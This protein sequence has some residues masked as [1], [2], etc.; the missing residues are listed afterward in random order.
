C[1]CDPHTSLDVS[2]T[3][4]G[5][6]RCQPNYSGASCDQCAPGYYG[7]PSCAPCGCSAEGSHYSH[8]DRLS[9]QCV[10][11][12]GVVG[13]RCDACTHGLYGIS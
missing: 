3:P 1:S 8:C 12:P 7:Y 2:C 11:R 6:C 4:S 13:R 9:G 10:C 5:Q